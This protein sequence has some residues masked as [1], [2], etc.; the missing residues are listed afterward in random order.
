MELSKH[1]IIDQPLWSRQLPRGLGEGE[2]DIP[3][4]PGLWAAGPAE[5]AGEEGG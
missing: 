2:W 3:P 1:A 4:P 5:E